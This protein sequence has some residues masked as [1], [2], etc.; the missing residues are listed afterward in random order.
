MFKGGDD[1]GYCSGCDLAVVKIAFGDDHSAARAVHRGP[2][3][4]S[5]PDLN[6][7]VSLRLDGR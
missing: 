1:T 5:S 6:H 2:A 4:A 3:H 7:P